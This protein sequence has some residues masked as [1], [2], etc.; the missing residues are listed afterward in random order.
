[1]VDYVGIPRPSSRFDWQQVKWEMG[2]TEKM[3]TC[4][5]RVLID[6]VEIRLRNPEYEAR[7]RLRSIL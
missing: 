4:L 5:M 6:N 3:S 2:A 7:S 1:M